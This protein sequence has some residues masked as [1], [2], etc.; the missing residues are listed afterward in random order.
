MGNKVHIDDKKLF[1]VEDEQIIQME[2][3]MRLESLGYTIMDTASSG[4]EFLEKISGEIPDLV[5]M[6]IS[7]KGKLTG[8]EAAQIMSEKYAIPVI[9]I[10]AYSDKDTLQKAETVFPIKLITKPFDDEEL[11]EQI[12]NLFKDG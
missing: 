4:E 8:I 3:K 11:D 10:T 7:L 12:K 6:D 1:I 9:F 2:L 5:L